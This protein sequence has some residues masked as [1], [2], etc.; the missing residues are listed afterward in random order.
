MSTEK[1]GLGSKQLNTPVSE[2]LKLLRDVHESIS[3]TILSGVGAGSFSDCLESF[4][5]KFSLTG[6]GALEVELGGKARPSKREELVGFDLPF[7]TMANPCMPTNAG[8]KR[9]LQ[10]CDDVFEGSKHDCNLFVKAA[11]R[12][13]FGDIFSGL[14][15]DG[16][17]SKLADASSGWSVTKSIVDSVN[18]AIAGDFVIGGMTS[19][20]LG[21]SHGHLAVVVGCPSQ[22]SG[23]TRVPIGYAG[24]VGG[25]SI[26]GDRL[27]ATFKAQ[28]VRD[29]K[30]SY[31]WK[32][33]TESAIYSSSDE[34]LLATTLRVSIVFSENGE[35]TLSYAGTSIR[36]LGKPGYAYPADQVVENIEGVQYQG[37]YGSAF[38]FRKWISSDFLDLQGN[39]ATMLWSVKIDGLHGVFIH[40]G[41]DTLSSNGGPSKGCIHLA[42]PNAEAFYRWISARA[43]ITISRPW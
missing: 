23:S 9:I 1:R 28:F 41:P 26:R 21:D 20:Q 19:K 18:H 15:A 12:P 33:L 14:D 7:E 31:F 11:S 32:P 25:V 6:V 37:D 8:A 38:K 4:S 10:T 35:G 13:Y 24:S 36:C 30:I 39:P 43:R 27:T 42:S 2:E 17:I 40:E 16:I 3:A 29:E 5:F 34:F 22:P